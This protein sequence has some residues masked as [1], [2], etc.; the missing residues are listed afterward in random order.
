MEKDIFTLRLETIGVQQYLETHVQP[1]LHFQLRMI[2]RMYD[3][4]AII[5]R[6]FCF[7]T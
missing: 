3:T 2:H 1:N 5:V 6:S 7:D 4:R